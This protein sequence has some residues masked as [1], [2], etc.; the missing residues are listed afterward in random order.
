MLG[1]ILLLVTN[2]LRSRPGR[3]VLAIRDNEAGAAVYGVNLPIVKTM[4]F[5]SSAAL[6]AGACLMWCLD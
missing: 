6:G 3:A 4:N 1:I 5:A 2:Y